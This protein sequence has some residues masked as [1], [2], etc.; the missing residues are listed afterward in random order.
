MSGKKYMLIIIV[1]SLSGAIIAF[2][3]GQYE[4][5]FISKL[6]V[7]FLYDDNPNHKAPILYI[8]KLKDKKAYLKYIMMD[9]ADYDTIP[10]DFPIVSLPWYEKIYVRG[11]L[12]DSLVEFYNTDYHH[13]YFNFTT[14][15]IHR[16]YVHDIQKVE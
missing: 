12:D 7:K 9:R 13:K 6:P 8:Q 11:Y 1:L 14:G 4:K 3:Y 16:Q 5:H 10:I 2:I 15:Y